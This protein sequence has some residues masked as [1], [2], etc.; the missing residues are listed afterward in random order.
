MENQVVVLKR[1]LEWREKSTGTLLMSTNAW[2]RWRGAGPASR[3][4]RLRGW[5]LDEGL[6]TM[7]SQ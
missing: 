5:G 7:D 2:A 6:V 4:E 3:T 1:A